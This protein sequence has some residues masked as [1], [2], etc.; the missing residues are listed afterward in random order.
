[1]RSEAV[2]IVSL[3][4]ALAPSPVFSLIQIKD[5]WQLS[6]MRLLDTEN[7]YSRYRDRIRWYSQT[8]LNA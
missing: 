2:T 7:I 5:A 6:S 1:M 3:E 8:P 4:M